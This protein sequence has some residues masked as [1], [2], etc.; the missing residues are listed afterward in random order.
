MTHAFSASRCARAVL[1]VVAVL[2]ASLA[3]PAAAGA[4]ES[5]ELFFS[6][7]VEGSANNK[8]L[9]IYTPKHVDEDVAA[10]LAAEAS[11]G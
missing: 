4:A 9:E 10:A 3:A 6:E 2:A 1:V 11:L 5:T 8:D 7:Y